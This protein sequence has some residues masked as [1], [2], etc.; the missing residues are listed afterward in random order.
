MPWYLNYVCSGHA[1]EPTERTNIVQWA[2][3]T[4]RVH[5]QVT[6][7]HVSLVAL[8]R[9]SFSLYN[10]FFHYQMKLEIILLRMSNVSIKIATTTIVD[11]D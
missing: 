2:G 8:Y 11:A 3:A 9:F 4:M 5:N 10:H 7:N 1:Q 6:I